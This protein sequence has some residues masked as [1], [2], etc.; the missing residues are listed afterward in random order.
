MPALY[1]KIII[2]ILAFIILMSLAQFLTSIHPPRHYDKQ[3]PTD[4]GLKYEK[5]SF[6]TSD[7][8]LLKGWLIDSKAKGT[9]IVGHGYP[10]EKGNILSLVTFLHPKYNLL[11]Y[12][13]RYFGESDG[14][15]TTIGLHEAEDVKSAVKFVKAKYGQKEPIALYGFSLSASAMLLSKE[16][17]KAVIAD[18]PY[19]NL[20]NMVKHVYRIFGPLKY[21]FVLTTNILSKLFFGVS[22]KHISP[23]NAV[24]E[25]AVPILLMHGNEDTQIPVQNAHE[26]KENNPNIE[27]WIVPNSDHGQ[28]HA[29]HTKKYEQRVLSFLQKHMEE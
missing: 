14:S 21:P 7:N 28:A 10:F 11:L 5:V 2:I 27:L 6:T 8:I 23:A 26:I 12:D 20:E 16:K 1:V 17:V 13:H 9:V 4:Y 25:T 29:M 24:K 22:P 18:S 3:T 15:Y 19:A